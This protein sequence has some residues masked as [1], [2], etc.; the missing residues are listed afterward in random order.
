M[1]FLSCLILLANSSW[2]SRDRD[3]PFSGHPIITHDPG[4]STAEG[5]SPTGSVSQPKPNFL[6]R[7][8]E[9]STRRIRR[10]GW[11]PFTD[12]DSLGTSTEVRRRTPASPPKGIACLV[13][14]GNPARDHQR[15]RVGE[16]VGDSVTLPPLATQA[17]KCADRAQQ[18]AV[19]SGTGN[20]VIVL[21]R[22]SHLHWEANIF[23]SVVR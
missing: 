9:E 3:C 16:S 18:K 4:L 10:G 8:T 15:R 13:N 7:G 14:L 1:R 5:D 19:W 21:Q 12:P 22:R 11:G 2:S 17:H 23:G 6:S 20:G